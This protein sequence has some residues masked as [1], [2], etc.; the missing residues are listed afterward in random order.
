MSGLVQRQEAAERRIL[1]A[2]ARGPMSPE[3]LTP[4]S[5]RLSAGDRNIKVPLQA[6]SALARSGL[7]ARNADRIELTRDGVSRARRLKSVVEPFREQHAPVETIP[8]ADQDGWTLVHLNTA[9]SPLAQLVRRKDADGAA[10]LT[11]AEFDAG[12]KLRADYTMGQIMPRVGANWEAPISRSR[13]GAPAS[14]LTDRALAARQRVEQ[15]IEAVGP[16]LS[17]VLI[18]VCCYLKGLGQVEHERRW[19]ARS[20]K[21][22]L[23][24]ALARLARHYDPT[25]NRRPAT[26][27]SWGTADHRPRTSG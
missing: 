12:E 18:D 19:P 9:E 16:E 23:K 8:I 27:V 24:S 14:D 21:L 20:A 26:I 7:I 2:L 10:F 6:V 1:F 3:A 4:G 13:R 11:E 22:I 25:R 15:A 5:I 17:G